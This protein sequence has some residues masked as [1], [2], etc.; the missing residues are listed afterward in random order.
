LTISTDPAVGSGES[1][2][3]RVK[4]SA[5]SQD[6]LHDTYVGLLVRKGGLNYDAALGDGSPSSEP[7]PSR[8]F[9]DCNLHAYLAD[10]THIGVNYDTGEFE[11]GPTNVITSGSIPGT[12]EW[13][14]IPAS[15]F[16]GTRFMI[17]SRSTAEWLS[18]LPQ[19]ARA[20][21]G[22]ASDTYEMILVRLEPGG[23][24]VKSNIVRGAIDAGVQLPVNYNV[25]AQ[26]DGTYELRVDAPALS[27]DIIRPTE[28]ITTTGAVCP[29]QWE[30]SA[31]GETAIASSTSASLYYALGSST[32]WKEIASGIAGSGTYSW[33]VSA[34]PNGSYRVRV[35]VEDDQGRRGEAISGLFSIRRATSALSVGPNPVRD[36]GC[37]F[38]YALPPEFASAFLLLF[39]I[40]GRKVLEIPIEPGTL[41]YPDA[42][43]W[44]PADEFGVPLA[45]GPYVCVLLAD[46][47]VVARVKLVI[48]R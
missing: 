45:N 17:D 32:A 20:A 5:E 15:L 8:R 7:D 34:V 35:V 26:P 4:F 38:F 19:E 2:Q 18:S 21:V 3:V 33:D 43:T 46:G 36:S 41:R 47:Q 1:T 11:A 13:I 40:T 25:V 24:V 16:D 9:P 31:A 10:G 27:V 37:A 12:G 28:G 30:V 39:D 48:Q 29:V 42:G 14:L 6:Y 44:D 22:T 23:E